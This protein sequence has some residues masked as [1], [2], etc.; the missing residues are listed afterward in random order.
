LGDE[1]SQLH[2]LADA[3]EAHLHCAQ[4]EAEQA[5]Q[6]L[7]KAQGI[8]IE[9]HEVA[10]HEKVALQEK[11]EEEKVQIQQEK[12]QLLA[13]RLEVKEA[14]NRELRSVIGLEPQAEY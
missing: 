5:T 1:P 10:E 12:E 8:L 6:A 11:I 7:K 9:Q 14:V 3:V 13:E 4:E 2:R